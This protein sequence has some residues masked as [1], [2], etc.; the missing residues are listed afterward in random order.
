MAKTS[1]INR[2]PAKNR[3][4]TYASVYGRTSGMR[5]TRIASSRRPS[6]PVTP[7]PRRRANC[8]LRISSITTVYVLI[9][10]AIAI[11]SDSP[12]PSYAATSSPS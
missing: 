11:V 9:S 5:P 8:Q 7:M 6:V 10:I 4:A 3:V 1:A 2:D 12:A